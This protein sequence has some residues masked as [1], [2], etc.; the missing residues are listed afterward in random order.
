MAH[1]QSH[2]PH[3]GKESKQALAKIQHSKAHDA[4]Q[5]A[6]TDEKSALV[7]DPRNRLVNGK[8]DPA[9]KELKPKRT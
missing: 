5:V 8:F 3:R 4:K 7:A 1:D 2:D 9:T 6:D